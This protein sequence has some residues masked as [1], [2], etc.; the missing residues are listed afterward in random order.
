MK[1]FNEISQIISTELEKLNWNK[2]PNGLYEPIGYVLS[3]GGKDR[4][5]VV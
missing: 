2:E 4:K 5:S 3:M 1:T